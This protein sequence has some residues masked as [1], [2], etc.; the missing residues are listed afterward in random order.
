MRLH[1]LHRSPH[2]AFTLVELLVALTIIVVIAMLAIAVAPNL[3]VKQRSS[4]GASQVQG[5]LFIAKQRAV[6]D[7]LI[8]GVQLIPDPTTGTATFPNGQYVTGIRYVEQP[9][10]F[11]QGN[12]AQ[13]SGN[14][15]TF[16]LPA[17]VD[18]RPLLAPGDY[19]IVNGTDPYRIAGVDPNT[20]NNVTLTTNLTAP[21]QAGSPASYRILRG[22]RPID[23]E[24]DLQLPQDVV[25]DL[26]FS[27]NV[28][29]S[30]TVLFAPSGGAPQDGM[31]SGKIILWVRDSSRDLA[32]EG[33]PTLVTV[34]TRTGA[35][36]A[37]PVNADSFGNTDAR[38]YY[39]FT[40]DGRNSGL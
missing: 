32:F 25:I 1:R 26:N 34:F 30:M 19:L 13:G 28:P 20:P 37:Y 21:I 27:Q 2:P 36:G 7:K 18:L 11:S 23:G 38:G 8:C 40:Q 3:D 15:V 9:A 24:A 31:T 17:G 29:A 16:A 4:L 14:A 35:I 33:E 12:I 39:F 10:P 5:W 6:R 22:A